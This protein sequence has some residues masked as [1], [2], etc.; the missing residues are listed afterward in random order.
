MY[1]FEYVNLYEKVILHI[2]I[3]T[4]IHIQIPIVFQIYKK[5]KFDGIGSGGVCHLLIP[6]CNLCHLLIPTCDLY[7]VRF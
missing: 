4:Q 6:T 1:E 3:N 7:L 2:R 5:I